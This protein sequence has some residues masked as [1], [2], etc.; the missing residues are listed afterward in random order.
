MI[1]FGRASVVAEGEDV[2]IV[3]YGATVY[4]SLQ[5]ARSFH[6]ET[7]K[8]AEVI[9]LRTLSPYDWEAILP[10]G[11]QDQSRPGRL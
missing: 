9:D 10:V 1:P 7:G 8:T 2:T 6:E 4:R 5:A 3:T 11:S